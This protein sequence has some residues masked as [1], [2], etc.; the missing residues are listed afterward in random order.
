MGVVEDSRKVTPGALFVARAGTKVNGGRFLADAAGRGA[1]A[2]VVV[3]GGGAGGGGDGVVGGVPVLVTSDLAAPS[4]LAQGFAGNPSLRMKVLGVTGTNG[5]TTTT[6]LLRHILG[7]LG[8]RCGMIGTVEIDDGRK[9]VES[10]MTTPGAAEL[11]EL[12]GRMA[13]NG[14]AAVAM[15][16]S[17][18]A[19]HQGRTAAIRFAGAGFTNLTGDHLDYHGT[20][21]EYAASK[22]KLF[23]QLAEGG[24]SGVAVVN[25]DDAWA[26]RVAGVGRGRGHRVVKFGMKGAGAYQASQINVTANG[27]RFLWTTPG[28]A[29]PV[30]MLLVGRH[31][32]ENAMV[33]M[34]LACE[35][36]GFGAAEVAKAM[37][38]AKG[39]P[40]RLE[41]VRCGQPF[42]VLVDYAHTDDALE[43]V[44]TALRPLVG[45]GAKLR[46]LFGC[47]GD[48]DR[49]KRPRMARVAERL[50]DEVWVT[51]DNPRTE[52][53]ND[54]L[55]EISAG[56]TRPAA[57]V[58]VDRRRAIERLLGGAQP[59]DIVL[60]AGKGH[61]TYQILGT[62][63]HHFDDR[64]EAMRVLGSG[65]V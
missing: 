9:V 5:K 50:A 17:S 23:E 47:G 24:A 64:E 49:T 38:D 18:H 22:A 58:E 12:L 27:T 56:L 39:A 65:V 29:V 54:I 51:S 15:E 55:A 10:E 7:R 19:L 35:V 37:G 53:P 20:M 33:A 61:E 25:G 13:A 45:A 4:K 21:E 2:A 41:A 43:N 60:I 48:R 26:D 44:L 42:A 59:G 8:V 57:A 40:G 30:E 11:G 32:I 1:V 62:S 63:K 3:G 16:V 36:F 14:C 31:N 6:Y 34:G 46:V 28:V 52:D